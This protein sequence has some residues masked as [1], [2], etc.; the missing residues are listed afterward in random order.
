MKQTPK[1]QGKPVTVG[2]AGAGRG[3]ELH[4]EAMRR[5]GGVPVRFKTVFARRQEQLD[6]AVARWGFEQTTTNFDDLV[7]DPEIDVIDICTPPFMHIEQAERALKAG[8]HVICEKPLTGYFGEPGDERPIGEKVSKRVMYERLLASMESLRQTV[9]ESDATFMYAENFVYAPAVQKAAEIVRA[10]KSHILYLKGEESL[11]GSSSRVAGEWEKTGGGTFIRTG[12]HPLAAIIWLK[13]QE[14]IARG[15][16]IRV[17]SVIADMARVTPALT[18]YEHRHIAAQPNDVEDEGTV[19]LRFSDGTVANIVACDTLLGG[20]KNTVELYCNDAAINCN[21]TMSNVMSTY[22][23]DEDGLD[24]VPLSE[25]LPAKTGWN[26]PFLSDEVLRGYADEM[27]DFMSAAYEGRPAM[28]GFDLAYDTARVM[29]AAYLAA[30][31]DR[32]IKL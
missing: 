11:K 29:Y 27:G 25:M 6:V 18:E 31:E 13:Q 14:G 3:T 22:L 24:D 7:N 17:E 12:S 16:D 1:Q 8:K 20:S 26:N 15:E 9:A 30:E 28:S 2:M 4:M 23:L 21:L 10:K 5:A 19:I 32:R